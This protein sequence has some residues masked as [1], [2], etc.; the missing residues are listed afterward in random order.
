MHDCLV[1]F[2]GGFFLGEPISL[3]RGTKTPDFSCS[4]ALISLDP[5][6][7]FPGVTHSISKLRV[8]WR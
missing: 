6:K 5:I 8:G 4:G 2:L 1:K 7:K 3:G